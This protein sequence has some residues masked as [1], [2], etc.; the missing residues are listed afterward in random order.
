MKFARICLLA[1]APLGPVHAAE[2]FVSTLGS[3]STGSGSAAMPFRTLGHVLSPALALTHPGDVINLRAPA[4]NAI[5]NEC[6]VRLRMPLTLRSPAGERAH[7]HCDINAVDTVTVQIDPE[8][9]GSRI[10]NL[11]LSGGYYY[12]LFLQTDWDSSG[13]PGGSGASNIVIED[14]LIHDSGRDAIKITPKSNDVTIRRCEIRDSG[15]RYP[16]GTPAEDK[17]AEGIDNVNGSRMKVQDSHIHD[18][19]TTGVYFKGGASDVVIERNVIERT[20]AAGILVGFDT[21]PEYFDTIANPQYY[22]AIRGIVRNNIVSDTAWAGIGLYAAQHAFIANNTLSRTANSFHAAIYFGVTLQDYDPIA[23]R[24]A[25]VNP[26]ILNNVIRQDGG[27]CIGIRWADEIEPTGL[28]G[29]LGNP[30]SNF[31]RFENI[32]GTCNFFDTRPGSAIDDGGSFAAWK[33]AESSDAASLEMPIVLATNGHLLAGSPLIDA[34]TPLAEVTD[35]VD[36][37]ARSAAPDIG[38][39]ELDLAQLFRNGFE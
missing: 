27:D 10:S 1:L 26:R 22:E 20:G 30:G 8:A 14:C 39:D 19:A 3:D 29:L 34:G 17:N 24:P 25:S 16:P 33:G 31:N 18:T 37:E 15:R 6:E 28:Y 36:A 21:S 12:A 23:G 35:D 9:S 32:G 4:G 7:I 2:W 38:A 5:Y 11:E 13:N